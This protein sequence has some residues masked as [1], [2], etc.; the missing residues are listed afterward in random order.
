MNAVR[1]YA[2]W[3]IGLGLAAFIIPSI[4]S[5]IGKFNNNAGSSI[6]PSKVPYEP[7]FRQDGIVLV[8]NGTDTTASFR[9]EYAK[10][11]ETIEIGMM[12]R[13]TVLMDMSMLFFMPGGDQPRSFWMKNTIVP[14][15]IIYINSSHDVVSVQANAEP[16]SLKSL[17]S[18][19]PASFVLETLGGAAAAAEIRVGTKLYWLGK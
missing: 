9:T 18:D 7:P 4:I 10:S 14:L 6:Q 5:G 13:R 19:A 3:I 17:P 1:K 8:V 12:Y 11:A 15:D 2:V 16:L